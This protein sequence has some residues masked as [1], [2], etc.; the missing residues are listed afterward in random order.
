MVTAEPMPAVPDVL[1]NGTLV[2]YVIRLQTALRLDA[3][4]LNRISR[5]Q[6]KARQ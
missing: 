2:E 1:T 5:L 3:D 4:K 6:P